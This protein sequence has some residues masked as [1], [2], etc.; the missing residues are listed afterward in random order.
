MPGVLSVFCW[1][2]RESA[3]GELSIDS[4]AAPPARPPKLWSTRFFYPQILRKTH[5]FC[6]YSSPCPDDG[7]SGAQPDSHCSILRISS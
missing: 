5:L 6:P 2:G 1:K 3:G 7:S 4:A